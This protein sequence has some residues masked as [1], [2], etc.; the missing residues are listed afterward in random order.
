MS[1]DYRHNHY[2]PVWYQ[3]RFLPATAAT[4]ELFYLDLKPGTFR[5]PRG[6]EHRR[7]AVKRTGIRNSFAQDDLYTTHFG[8]H[9]STELEQLFFGTID[10]RG[11]HAVEY[12]STYNHQSADGAQLDSL[13]AYMCVQKL[14]TPKGLGWLAQQAGTTNSDDTL[15]TMLR[16]QQLFA[17]I[18][19]ECIW[20]IADASNS[21]TKFI[22]SDHPITVYNRRCGPRSSWCRGYNDADIAYSATHTIFP[23]SLDKVLLLTNLTWVRDPYQHETVPRPNPDPWRAA[24]FNVMAIQSQRHLTELEVEQINFIIKNRAL[25]YVGAADEE[26]LYPE[27][28]VSKDDWSGYGDGYLLMPDPRAVNFGG[29]IFIGHRDGTV[30]HFDAYGRRPW[31]KDYD[32]E[33]RVNTEF[34]TL[35]RFK[36]ECARRYGPYRRGR[37]WEDREDRDSDEM[38]QYYLS[39]DPRGKKQRRQ[40]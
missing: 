4:N 5:D 32:K 21:A 7:R 36:G 29:E 35:H 38:H 9:E 13:I 34:R 28:Q 12:F 31:Q 39:L 18:W 2:V 27:R 40:Q 26:W 25:R 17:A 22:I 16:F 23:L 20:L 37:R 6:Y 24:M 14:R 10:S 1:S 33:G 15:K 30:S 8:G 11:R 19:A 3:K